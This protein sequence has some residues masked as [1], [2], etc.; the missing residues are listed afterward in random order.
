MQ[1]AARQRNVLMRARAASYA[2]VGSPMLLVEPVRI[3]APVSM[4]MPP[5]RLKW[6]SSRRLFFFVS[7]VLA[8]V[9]VLDACVSTTGPAP[10]S[11]TLQM[12]T[13]PSEVSACTAVGEIKVPGG[14]PNKDMQFRSQAVR[15]G[16]D[17][18]LVTIFGDGT[19]VDGIA[20]RC[21][22]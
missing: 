6:E 18:A 9:P 8:L 15:F 4:A 17:T 19:P 21:P 11:Y 12:T 14:A 16:A 3:S 5:S 7:V 10:G 13:D 20:Y 1:G 22:Q 2:V